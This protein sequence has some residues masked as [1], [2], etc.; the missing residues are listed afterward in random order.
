LGRLLPGGIGKYL[1]RPLQKTRQEAEQQ[2]A[3]AHESLVRVKD[4]KSAL[5]AS[6]A[7]LEAIVVKFEAAYPAS[8]L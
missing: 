1:Q 4:D 2:A 7:A 5:E 8:M 6:M 3:I